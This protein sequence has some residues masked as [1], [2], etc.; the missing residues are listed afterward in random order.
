MRLYHQATLCARDMA[1]RGGPIFCRNFDFLIMGKCSICHNKSLPVQIKKSIFGRFWAF[2]GPKWP[3][4]DLF[5]RQNS[6]KINLSLQIFGFRL[7]W[8]KIVYYKVLIKLFMALSHHRKLK[9]VPQKRF[10]LRWHV[11]NTAKLFEKYGFFF[12][13]AGV[14]KVWIF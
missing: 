8:K 1:V 3:V 13:I 14:E 7:F 5:L 11:V 9:F 2:F 4:L 10:S 6:S 12:E